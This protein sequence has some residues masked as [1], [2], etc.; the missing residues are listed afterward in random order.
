MEKSTER[1]RSSETT[2]LRP[3]AQALEST[4]GRQRGEPGSVVP[5]NTEAELPAPIREAAARGDTRA[6]DDSLIASWPPS[7]RQRTSL[8]VNGDFERTGVEVANIG[9]VPT[10]ELQAALALTVRCLKPTP[11]TFVVQE[12]TKCAL[13]T[14]AR[15]EDTADIQARAVIFAEDLTEFPADVIAEAFKFWRRTE[16]FAPAV[17]D[18]RERC[19][20]LAGVRY[21]AKRTIER[22]LRNRA[23]RS[24]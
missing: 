15:A 23:R 18:I 17:A 3:L 13:V 16:K 1:P 10:E 6:V 22:E 7:L 2:G 14:K 4:T 12:F 24:A 20:R 5:L 8:A 9:S 21:S 11:A 19:W